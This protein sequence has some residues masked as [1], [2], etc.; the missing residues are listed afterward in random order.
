MKSNSDFE[1]FVSGTAS[2][3]QEFWAARVTEWLSFTDLE[4]DAITD[5]LADQ[6]FGIRDADED[7]DY[8]M[9]QAFNEQKQQEIS[10]R[11]VS[12]G[13]K[14]EGHETD[15]EGHEDEE[16]DDRGNNVNE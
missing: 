13:E 7:D 3:Y 8:E 6:I 16:G 9:Q 10:A 5:Y 2:V 12:D 14:L 11:Q 4:R 1:G 15:G